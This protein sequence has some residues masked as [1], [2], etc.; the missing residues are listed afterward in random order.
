VLRHLP[1]PNDPNI[2]NGF[3]HGEDAAVYRLTDDR[4]LV[5]SVDY[6]TPVVDDPYTF[7]AIA[8]AN[9]LSDLYAMGARPTLALNLI[10]YPVK[11][12]PLGM[13]E[14]ILRG[15]ADKVI[16]AGASLIGGHSIDDHEPK[17]GLAVTGLIHPNRVVRNAGARPGDRLVLTKPL[18]LGIITT[19]LDRGLVDEAAIDRAVT[20][21]TTLNAGA[22]EA[23]LAVGVHAATDVTGFGLL[24]HLHEMLTASGVGARVELDA[25]PVLDEAWGLAAANCI[26]DGSHSN[27]RDLASFIIWDKAIERPAQMVL[28]DAQTSGGLLL[29]VPPARTDDLLAALREQATPAAA[30]IGEVVAGELPGRITVTENR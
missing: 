3:E 15:G 1:L 29:A 30:V 25:V 12:L 8:A 24:G 19:G 9:A 17:Y 10:G 5:Q 2:L 28:C 14:E 7:G 16:E 23:M 21:M 22:A 27:F 6:I 11:S 4:A 18:G 20:V 26:P 13:M